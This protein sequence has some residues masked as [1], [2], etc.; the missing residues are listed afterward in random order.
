[1]NPLTNLVS[2]VVSWWRGP[3]DPG[4]LATTAEAKHLG[5]NRDTIRISQ[6]TV[7]RVPLPPGLLP[8]PDVLDPGREHNTEYH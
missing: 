5:M 8:T 6:E 7:V 4:S 2:R 1:M 3:S